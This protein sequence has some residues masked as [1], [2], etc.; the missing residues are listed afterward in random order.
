MTTVA[1]LGT[2]ETPAENSE[3]V[4]RHIEAV[5]SRAIRIHRDEPWTSK[6]R[7]ILGS[8]VVYGTGFGFATRLWALARAMGKQTI[9]HWVG[10]DVLMALEDPRMQRMARTASRLIGRHLTVAPW[11]VEELA[12]IGIRADL[13]PLVTPVRY[14]LRTQPAPAGVLAYLPDDRADFYGSQVVYAT[15]RQWPEIPFAVVAGT[16]E[17]QPAIPNVRYLGW[18]DDIAPLY[19]QYP[20]LLRAARHD[21]LPKMVLEALAFGNQVIFEY[22]L[23]GCRHARTEAEVTEAIR[24]IVAEGCPINQ[25]GHRLVLEHYRHDRIVGALLQTLGVSPR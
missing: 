9:N 8:Q 24:A 17:R 1:V 5:G 6:A 22:P 7:K 13:I 4:A 3:I 10:T 14:D 19:Q 18:V 23:E 12:T 11:L 25:A 16:Q 2:F 15:A 21:G 20:I